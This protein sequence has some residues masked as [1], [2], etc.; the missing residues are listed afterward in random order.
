MKTFYWL[1][2]RETWEH[3]SFVIVPLALGGLAVFFML[4][5]MTKMSVHF[6][7][8][9]HIDE[10][11]PLPEDRYAAMRMGVITSA[12][13]FN[14][15]M[16][17]VIAVYLLDALY[18]DRRDRSILFWK[19]LPVSDTAVVLSKLATATL[20]APLITLAVIAATQLA[21][22]TIA[23]G[24]FLLTGVT[25]WGWM[26]NP[27]GWI[28]GWLSL[29]YGYLLLSAI[30]LPYLAWLLLASSWARRTPF[31]WAVVPP[32]A[33]MILERWFLGSAHLLQWTFGHLHDLLQ[34]TFNFSD[35]TMKNIGGGHQVPAQPGLEFFAQPALWGGFCAAALFVAGAIWLRRYRDET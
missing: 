33:L 17:I 8:I 31:L 26:W 23:S 7:G 12:V 25:G 32:L 10:H 24:F 16:L 6:E 1:I 29:G 18:G 3:R 11:F 30:L 20:V 35:D 13:P 14:I 19:S 34:A 21:A 28:W 15:V 22:L 9:G 4:M 2:R 5:A 27:L